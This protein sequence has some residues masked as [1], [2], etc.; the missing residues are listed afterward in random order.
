MYVCMYV[1]MYACMCIYMHTCICKYIYYTQIDNNTIIF[2]LKW[3]VCVW[4]CV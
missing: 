3:A 1:C 4:V 2:Q